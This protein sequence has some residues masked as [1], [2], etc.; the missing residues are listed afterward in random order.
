MSDKRSYRGALARSFHRANAS[1]APA[2]GG[3]GRT[4]PATAAS[5][6]GRQPAQPGRQVH[7]GPPA[8]RGAQGAILVG[9]GTSGRGSAVRR[10]VRRFWRVHAVL[11]QPVGGR[12]GRIRRAH[13]NQ[14]RQPA[15]RCAR[16]VVGPG[17]SG[18]ALTMRPCRAADASA[19]RPMA[20]RQSPR[21]PRPCSPPR[22][23]PRARPGGSTSRSGAPSGSM[24][25]R[26]AQRRALEEALASVGHAAVL[27][28][29]LGAPVA[30]AP[31]RRCAHD[32]GRTPGRPACP[33]RCGRMRAPAPSAAGMLSSAKN[34]W[35]AARKPSWPSHDLCPHAAGL[36]RMRGLEDRQRRAAR[37]TTIRAQPVRRRPV[38]GLVKSKPKVSQFG[39]RPATPR[40]CELTKSPRRLPHP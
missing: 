38:P 11:P 25:A 29:A 34:Q 35:A 15:A 6:L 12:A 36:C 5:G 19:R 37:R 1:P 14:Q 17:A 40:T 27:P 26:R 23:R 28:P 16:F 7:D 30:R 13:V 8:R 22:D 21:D 3:P 31:G 33:A 10:P 9:R 2:I 32:A 4:A 18:G 39:A 20:R 24:P